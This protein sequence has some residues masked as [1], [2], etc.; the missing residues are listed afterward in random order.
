MKQ[1]HVTHSFFSCRLLILSVL[2]VI[3]V[4]MVVSYMY[5]YISA[6]LSTIVIG[7]LGGALMNL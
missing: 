5:L 7:M 1:E 4:Y 3:S 6:V 2:S